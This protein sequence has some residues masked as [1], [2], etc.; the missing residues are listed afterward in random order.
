[1]KPT[2]FAALAAVVGISG[3]Q[4]AVQSRPLQDADVELQ[5][6][7]RVPLAPE[8]RP[9]AE[10]DLGTGRPRRF[11]LDTGAEISLIDE[12]CV[13]ECGLERHPYSAAFKTIGSGGGERELR[14]YVRLDRL[15]LGELIVRDSRVTVVGGPAL[16]EAK[17]DGILGQDLLSRL[18]IIVDSQRHELHVLPNGGA[19]AIRSCIEDAKI[20]N[21]AWASATIEFHPLPILP[22]DVA[23]V[24][25]TLRLEIDTGAVAS[26]LPKRAITALR[27][28][29]IGR[30]P[31]GGVDGTYETDAYRLEH[32]NLFG[33]SLDFEVTASELEQGLLGMDVLGSLVFVLDGPRRTLWLH[34]RQ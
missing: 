19:D 3:C 20:G 4:P 2:T 18:V 5:R 10:V 30:R 7:C 25:E 11:L 9:I 21:G 27:L 6:P 32:F 26:S 23:G 33:L 16:A 28:A 22:L 24:A 12:R 1:M 8:D 31:R 29:P 15:T 13:V 14:D 17:V 34:H